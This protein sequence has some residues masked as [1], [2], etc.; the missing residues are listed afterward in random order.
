MPDLNFVKAQEEEKKVA[1][2]NTKTRK[3]EAR[4]VEE[5][6]VNLMS[7][8]ALATVARG[9]TRKQLMIL[10]WSVC[11]AVV[12]SVVLYGFVEVYAYFVQ[13]SANE[14][15]INLGKIDDEIQKI[16]Q[17]GPALIQFQN[18]LSTI[19]SLLDSHAYWSQFIA[20]LEA[21]T[22]PTV[23]YSGLSIAAGSPVA[24]SATAP[25]FRTLAKQLL[26]YQQAPELMSA[27]QISSGN[28]TL[29]QFGNISGVSFEV[30]FTINPAVLKK[31]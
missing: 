11:A 25:D 2:A 24:F 15:Q 20:Q 3:S 7:K 31:K 8:E 29:D 22:L 26:I 4:T 21:H 30:S 17:N 10:V 19:K 23:T 27:V 6:G 1:L 16:E 14:L 5:S 9:E 18:K 12:L 28:A 13:R